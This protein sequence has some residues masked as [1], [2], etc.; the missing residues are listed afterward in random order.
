MVHITHNQILYPLYGLDYIK[1]LKQLQVSHYGF[2]PKNLNL[3]KN[4]FCGE[5]VWIE[6]NFLNQ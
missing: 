5:L 3:K 2:F 1:F 6:G 4:L